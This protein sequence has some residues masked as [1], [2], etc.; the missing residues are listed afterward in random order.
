MLFNIRY[1]V[2]VCTKSSMDPNHFIIEL[3]QFT[4]MVVCHEGRGT[5]GKL[6]NIEE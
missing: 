1:N 5:P 4:K 3:E 6:T 2:I